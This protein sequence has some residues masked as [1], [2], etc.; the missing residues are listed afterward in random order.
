MQ[1]TEILQNV[2][3]AGVC[4][5]RRLSG[6]GGVRSQKLLGSQLPLLILSALPL[7]LPSPLPLPQSLS[8]FNLLSTLRNMWS[9][10]CMSA[11]SFSLSSSSVF[12]C[13]R[14]YRTVIALI[15][16]VHSSKL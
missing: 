7:S 11:L 14:V 2:L 12:V 9:F 6:L 5:Y 1:L 16:Q 15:S 10:I 8:L 13:L 3:S 4:K